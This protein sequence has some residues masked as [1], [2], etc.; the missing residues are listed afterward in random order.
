MKYMKKEYD[1]IVCGGGVAGVSAA[2]SSARVGLSTLIIEKSAILGGLATSGLINWFEPL[3]DGEGQQMCFSQVEE[4]YNLATK[5]GYKTENPNW[6]KKGLRKSSWFDHNLFALSLTRLLK[7]N[8][9]DICFETS[10]SDVLVSNNHIDEIEI[11]NVSGKSRLKAKVFVDATGSAYLFRTAGAKV[12]E[13]VNYL[14]YATTTYKDGLNKP[15]FQYS[16]SSLS[17][18]G[19]PE[20]LKT[21]SGLNIDD[22]NEF[23]IR[24]QELCL[25]EFEQGRFKDISSLPSIS[26]L[27]KIASING[28]YCLTKNDENKY[29]KDSIGAVGVFNK[30][31]KYYEIPFGSLYSKNISNLFACG[32]I[33]SSSDEGWEAIRVIPSCILTGEAVGLASYLLLQNKLDIKNLQNLLKERGVRLHK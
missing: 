27:R 4:L 24:G 3:C 25:K 15:S 1:V 8:N 22:V 6:S 11:L 2:L 31:G 14:T 10:V 29:C 5:Y 19:H 32:R 16:G 9:V 20:G 26:Q 21:F 28:E 7:E 18:V 17:G 30:P 13:G 23:L 33:I 12:R